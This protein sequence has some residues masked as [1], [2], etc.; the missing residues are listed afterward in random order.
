MNKDQLKA[1]CIEQIKKHPEHRSAICDIF[2]LAKNE[3]EGG[4]SETHEVQLAMEDIDHIVK[5]EE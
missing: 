3:I 4:S 5:G 1:Y 2:F